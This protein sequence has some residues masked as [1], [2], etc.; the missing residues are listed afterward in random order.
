MSINILKEAA[1]F[2]CPLHPEDA[3]S[4]YFE[5]TRRDIPGESSFVF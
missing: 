2:V 5:I 3:V 4:M 1:T